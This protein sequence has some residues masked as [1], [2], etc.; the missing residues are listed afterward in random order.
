ML[1]TARGNMARHKFKVGQMIDFAPARPGV[2][3]SGRQ[4]KIVR[5]LPPEGGEFQ[6]RIKSVYEAVERMARESELSQRSS[7]ET[8]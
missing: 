6:Y 7:D 2:P 4:Y 8:S 5:L 1:L 3:T